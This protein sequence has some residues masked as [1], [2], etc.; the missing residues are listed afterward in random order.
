[1]KYPNN[2]T[3]VDRNGR[4]C[5]PTAKYDAVNNVYLL[6]YGDGGKPVPYTEK[7]IG[8]LIVAYYDIEPAAPTYADQFSFFHADT[9]QQFNMQRIGN[10][11]VV[12]LWA[13]SEDGDK[14]RGA[15]YTAEEIAKHFEAGDWRE[16]SFSEPVEAERELVFPFTVRTLSDHYYYITERTQDGVTMTHR[17]TGE[18]Y[19]HANK[20][21]AKRFIRDNLW[22][23][24]S[25]GPQK[26]VEQPTSPSPPIEQSPSTVSMEDTTE[27]VNR[28]AEATER[29]N[30]ALESFAGIFADVQHLIAPRMEITCDASREIN[31]DDL[32][33]GIL[34]ET[35]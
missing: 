6:D 4:G 14:Y 17:D 20:E 24:T 35:F 28:L 9:T 8:A 13:C 32:D 31:W 22:T 33:I 11:S 7:D 18:A 2:F 3:L 1:M 12:P 21:D 16:I 25:V 30:I 5:D 23:V 29:L 19:H 27:A 15:T 26:A 10:H 34:R